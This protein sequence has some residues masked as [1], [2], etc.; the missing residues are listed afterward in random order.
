MNTGRYTLKLFLTDH[1]LD[2]IIIPEIQR[3][4]VWQRSNV[5]RLLQSIL[6]NS[7]K[8][9][10]VSLGITDELL[11]QLPP[12]AREAIIREQ[13]KN[14]VF[15]N[16]GFIY[17]YF[18]PELA[19]RFVLI[20]GQQ[21]LTTMFLTLLAL[22]VKEDKQ[23]Q[24][25]RTYFKDNILKFDYKVRESSHDFILNFVN[26]VL[27]NK[28]IDKIKNEYWYFSEYEYDVTIQSVL[29]NYQTIWNFVI[30]N[31]L[32]LSY[33]EDFVEFWYFD[34]NKSKQGEELY[35]YMNS[36]GETVSPN[37]SVKANLL[38]GLSE[39]EK[40]DWGTK[41]EEWQNLFWKYRGS[42]K[43]ADKG[44]EEF[45]RW[46]K[47]I[48]LTKK[49]SNETV[50]SQAKFIR[51]IKETKKIELEG[52]TLI[53][54]EK[55]YNALLKLVE[56]KEE[57]KFDVNWLTGA[58]INQKE[59][60]TL[61]YIKLMPML[62][63]AEKYPDCNCIDIKR[64]ARFFY[65]ITRSSEISKNPFNSLVNAINLTKEFL[66]KNYDDITD[67]VNF[68]D[69]YKTIL[70]NEEVTKLTIYKNNKD[71][72]EDIEKTFWKA[73]DYKYCDG[74]IWLIWDCIN[75]NSTNPFDFTEQKLLEFKLC[76]D[77]FI[78][79]FNNPDD[80]LR[81]AILTKGDYLVHDGYSTSL[82]NYRYSFINE[83]SRWKSQLSSKERIKPYKL[84]IQD[85]NQRKTDNNTKEDVVNEIIKKYLDT[86]T[87]KDWIYYFVKE[88]TL[89]SY[90]WEKKICWSDDIESIALLQ[91]TK[92]M[93]GSW[94]YLKN[95]INLEEV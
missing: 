95:K 85:Y 36:R 38:K 35:L 17:A 8:Q 13:E 70:T 14:K 7:M 74:K 22:S 90:C 44:I 60:S 37:E 6:D 86:T 2:Q 1:N 69:N 9:S 73:E 52:L 64:V 40:H 78:Y 27:D 50:D 18:D 75:F 56:Y 61:D 76:F 54:I 57:V 4:Y 10:N 55:Y 20:D 3:D 94:C 72:R 82:E 43:N 53:H 65:N 46:I 33:I 84:L 68:K 89:L 28:N 31:D 77:N 11:N 59:I 66:S 92:A 71:I 62:M 23:E 63:F 25:S 48:E 81:R 26:Y 88:P 58:D 67:I 87:Q 79:L 34:T 30:N 83:E 47:I 19:G 42:N 29:N 24:F 21:R 12:Q 45:L 16:I 32:P 41:W 93:D 91:R 51:Q 5:E 39:T 15:C 80:L 49:N